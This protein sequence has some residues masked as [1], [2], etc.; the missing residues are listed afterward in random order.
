MGW[1]LVMATVGAC[2]YRFSGKINHFQA[3]QNKKTIGW[4][5]FR[6]EKKIIVQIK[7]IC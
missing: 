7:S 4:S 1:C 2:A 3:L 6:K 5:K